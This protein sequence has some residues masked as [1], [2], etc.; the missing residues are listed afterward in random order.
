VKWDPASPA[1]KENDASVF[2]QLSINPR[3]DGRMLPP[4]IA[5]NPAADVLNQAI[6]T[7]SANTIQHD[8]LHMPTLESFKTRPE[9]TPGTG[10]GTL[11][12]DMFA[13][14]ITGKEEL[15]PAFDNFVTE[16]KRRGGEDAI[17]EATEW[18]NQFHKK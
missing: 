16:W 17:K 3:G 9:L 1:N 7:A 18:Y 8:G 11:F 12:L 6:Q 5:A 14:V 13:K 4:V 2:Y 15:D 10:A